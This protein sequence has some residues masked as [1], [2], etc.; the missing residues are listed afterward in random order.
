MDGMVLI[1]NFLDADTQAEVVRSCA[2]LGAGPGGF[3]TPGYSDGAVLSLR[4][5]CLG[6][7]W[8]PQIH[9]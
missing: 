4:M 8:E 5:M 6:K 2:A 9:G 7:H 3:I 1:R